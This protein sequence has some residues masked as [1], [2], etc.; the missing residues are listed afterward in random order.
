MTAAHLASLVASGRTEP[1]HPS[2][3]ESDTALQPSNLPG[4]Q[5]LQN[6]GIFLQGCEN[7]YFVFREAGNQLGEAQGVRLIEA[8]KAVQ[9][10][11]SG[12]AWLPAL[13]FPTNYLSALKKIDLSG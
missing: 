11:G 6:H 2:G 9:E 4:P 5:L 3:P 8:D 12:Q 10:A 1:K 7:C 13:H